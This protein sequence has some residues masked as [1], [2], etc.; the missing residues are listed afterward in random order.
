MNGE[1]ENVVHAV[2]GSK[3]ANKQTGHRAFRVHLFADFIITCWVW[4]QQLGKWMKQENTI[5][6]VLPL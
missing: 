4:K 3:Q 6:P 5:L 2:L 1:F